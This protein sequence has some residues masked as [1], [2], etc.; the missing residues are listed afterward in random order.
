MTKETK[1]DLERVILTPELARK[2]F[3][4]LGNVARTPPEVGIFDSPTRCFIVNVEW[5]AHIA[6]MVHLLADVSSWPEADD[7]SY[8][9]IREI[10]KF[11]QGM[12]CM[13]FQLRQKPTDDCILEQSLDG[14]GTWSDVFDFSLCATI[15]DQSRQVSISNAVTNYVPTIQDIYN[16]FITNYAGSPADVHPELEEPTGD[17]S[18]YAA[19]YCNAIW[20][21]V[22]V[23]SD[24]AVSYYTE[25]V[26]AAQNE[27]NFFV[28]IALFTVAAI[29]IA[30]AIPTGGASLTLTAMAANSALIGASIGLAAGL[31]NYATDYLQQHTIDQFQDTSAREEVACYLIDEVAAADNTL[32]AMQAALASHPLTDNAAV[33]ADFLA[34]SLQADV[35]YAAFLEKWNNNLEYANVGIDLYCPCEEDLYRNWI[36]DF[37]A[38]LGDFTLITGTLT[39][40]RIQ[41]VD[42]G[43]AK[44]IELTMPFDPD[45]RSRGGA[46]YQ[47]RI[48]GITHGSLDSGL[49]RFRVTPGTDV[50]AATTMPQGGFLPNGEFKQCLNVTTPPGYVEGVNQIYIH[51]Q[52]IDN[53]TSAIFLDKVEIQFEEG[54]HKGGYTT[55]DGNICA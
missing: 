1:N 42:M 52:V 55:D 6:G 32:A 46:L 28:G 17:D 18:A 2:Q 14:G 13:E 26:N 54:F 30:A 16:N 8:F 5:W 50:G 29:G 10:L 23:V 39:G 51:V 40:G 53:A 20:T 27:F 3:W 48:D 36:W 31:I 43:G 45:W 33:I 21:L 9:A 25:T 24:N 44:L 49:M 15:Q 38:G 4:E 37:S 22:S 12:E 19:A 41:G 34:I 47:E 35:T 7:E 11:M